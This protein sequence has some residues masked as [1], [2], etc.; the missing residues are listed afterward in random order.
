MKKFVGIDLGSNSLRAVRAGFG[1]D[2]NLEIFAEFEA[3]VR[4]AENLEKSGKIC[5]A[6]LNRILNALE[7]MKISLKM[8]KDDE[9]IALSTQALR[10]ASNSAEI[11]EKISQK[12]EIF[13]KIIS[14]EQEAQISLLSPYFSR[15]KLAQKLPFLP[16]G[17][18][19]VLIDM[20]GGSSEFIFVKGENLIEFKSIDSIKLPKFLSKSFAIGIVSAKDRY[21]TKN[22]LNAAMSDILAPIKDFIKLAKNSGFSPKFL[23][24]NS[25]TPTTIAAFKQ[26][27]E[28]Y[29]AGAVFGEELKIA[30]FQ[31]QLEK[32]LKLTKS[33]Q[34]ELLGDFKADVLPFGVELF[35]GFMD[36]LGF[37]SCVV[38]DEGIREGAIYAHALGII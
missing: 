34:N 17:A 22:A 3:T 32:Y 38:I 21:K 4:S 2:F 12:T 13:F 37:E 20:G 28:I 16:S 19:F 29:S 25:G 35:C 24:A 18:D 30:D 9:I 15:K 26:N 8:Q 14:G 11:L 1:G 27:L 23:L 36:A 7:K 33:E 31:I 6:A 5:E 10:K